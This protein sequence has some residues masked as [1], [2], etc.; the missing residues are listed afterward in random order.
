MINV[1]QILLN[2]QVTKLMTYGFGQMF[3]LVTPLIIIPYIVG[4]CGEENFGKVGVGLAVSFFL[5]VFVDYGADLV[6][7]R[8]ASLNRNNHKALEQLLL[9]SYYARAFIFI[10]IVIAASVLFF[11]VPLFVREQDMF[12]LSLSILAGQFLS[13]VW[14]LQGV[15]N[16][17]WITYGNILSKAIYLIGVYIVVKSP[18]D[19]IYVNLLWGMGMIFSNALFLVLIFKRHNFKLLRVPFPEIFN[20]LKRDFTMFTSQIF[21]ALQLNLPI[22]IISLLG[23]NLMA[24][25]YKIIEQVIVVFKT[26]I[27][28]FFNY[29]FP[30]ICYSAEQGLNKAIKG[31]MLYN[32]L[33]FIFIL[34]G[35]AVLYYFSY[36]V[37][38]YFNTTNRYILSRLLQIAVLIPLLMAVSIPLKQLVLAFNHKQF[39]IIVTTVTVILCMLSIYILLPVYEVYG[40]FYS[41]IATELLIIFLYLYRLKFYNRQ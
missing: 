17:K 7:V 34:A 18:Q 28:L 21:V 41:L 22:I 13:P 31:W 9:T 11:M 16:V 2:G 12:F 26:Y 3:N 10:L 14:F 4:I 29:V 20:F 15:E 1:K 24:G 6:G 36:D 35:M 39:Y 19:Y 25:Q 5:I 32:G 40:A 33:N 37:V 30:K 38:A 23:G 27:F 8:E